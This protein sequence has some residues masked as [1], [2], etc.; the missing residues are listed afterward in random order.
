MWQ[1]FGK[2]LEADLRKLFWLGGILALVLLG[3]GI[4]I[5]LC[6]SGR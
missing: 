2:N 4:A 1:F 3:G 5:G 6:F